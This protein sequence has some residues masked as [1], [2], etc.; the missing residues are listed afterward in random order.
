M[1]PPMDAT[2]PKTRANHVTGSCSSAA[3][4]VM[5]SLFACIEAAGVLP[6]GVVLCDGFSFGT[7][8]P[9]FLLLKKPMIYVF[10]NRWVVIG[11]D[12]R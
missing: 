8:A 1:K 5:V 6:S 7:V 2:A 9:D 12:E 4:L 3:A 10:P 11:I